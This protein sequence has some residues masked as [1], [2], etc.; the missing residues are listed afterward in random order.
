MLIAF[1]RHAS[2]AWNAAGRMQG[3]RDIELDAAGRAEAMTWRLP[4]DLHEP[5]EWISSPLARAIETAAIVSGRRPRVAP[6][7]IEM[8]W[9][10]WEGARLD[11]LEAGYGDAFVAN[12]RRGLDFRPPGGESPREVMIRVAR[13][14]ASVDTRGPPIVAV[15]HNGVLRALLAIAADW[16]MTGKP[17]VKL[18][19]ATL[20]RF[21]LAS[22]GKL[23][24]VGWNVP[25]AVAISASRPARQPSAPSKALP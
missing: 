7:L 6:A 5:I 16:D 11:E 13:W 22:G 23:A 3:H 17:P 25:L 24:V 8:D 15:A 21:V 19:P 20:H 9:G 10:D 4:A 18:R 1:L 14:L 2:T 12:A